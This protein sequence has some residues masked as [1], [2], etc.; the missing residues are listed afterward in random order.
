MF[1]ESP[2]WGDRDSRIS[3]ACWTASLAEP[4]IPRFSS[5]PCLKKQGENDDFCLRT[6]V[7]MH[8]Y[9]HTHGEPVSF[10]G[11]NDRMDEGLL[12]GAEMT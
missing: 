3:E 5:R 12:T 2:R 8:K 7:C 10:V 6:Y 11:I 4:V 1:L 9:T